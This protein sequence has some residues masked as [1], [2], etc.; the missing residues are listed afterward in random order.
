MGLTVR[1]RMLVW[2]LL[3]VLPAVVVGWFTVGLI[4][5]RLSDRVEVDLANIRRLEAAR[6]NEALDDYVADAA[7][8]AAGPHVIDFANGV[9]AAREGRGRRS[10]GGYDGFEIVDPE[11]D[12][13]LA[14]LAAALQNKARTT[15]SEVVEL[16]L[17]G[18]DGSVLGE[19]AGFEWEPYDLTLVGRVLAEG[20]PRF[21]NAYRTAAGDDRLGLATPILTRGGAVVGALVLET[22]LGPVVDLVV[23]HEGF[24]QTSEA[25]IAQPTPDGD[26]EFIT[27]LRFERDAAFN[28]VVP[29]AKGLPINQSLLSPEGQVLR[30]PDYRTVDSILAI[31]TL[32]ATGWGLVVKIDAAEAYAPVGEVR[33]ALAFA[34]LGTLLVVIG[35]TAVLLNPLGRRLRRLSLAA[36][37]VAAGRYQSSIGD[38]S[39]DEIGVLARSIDQLAADLDADI[40]MRTLV[41]N[42]LR[43][44][45]THDDLTEIHNRHYA[46]ARIRELAQA[47]TSSWS[48]LFLDLDSFKSVNDS[49][50]HGVGDEVL[51]AVAGRLSAS[52]PGNA[53]V[54]RWGGDEFVI[55][56]PDTTRTEAQ[57]TAQAIRELFHHPVAT[58]AGEQNVHCSIGLATADTNESTL[59]EILNT[60]D[61]AM[62]AQKPRPR[63]GRPARSTTEQTIIDALND[64]RVHV[65]YQPIV[66]AAGPEPTVVG[67]EALV[68]LR[69]PEGHYLPPAEFLPAVIDR[70][71]GIDLDAQVARQAL[72]TCNRWLRDGRVTT[73][74]QI[75]V[76]L[77]AGSLNDPGL[78]QRFDDLLRETGLPPEMLVLEISETADRID[79]AALRRLTN[80]GIDIA[81]DD[82]GI[83]NSNYDRLL[84]VRPRYAK[85]DRR[86]LTARGDESLVLE[87]LTRTCEALNLR[88]VA[89]GI[90]TPAQRQL[91]ESLNIAYHQGFLFGQAIPADEF[92]RTWLAAS[93]PSPGEPTT[94]HRQGLHAR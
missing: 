81:L 9:A 29:A 39:S 28:K 68:R 21:G 88:M 92:S 25:H 52:A 80:A 74:F 48:L 20:R 22:N 91:A 37:Q 54:A 49:H 59:D 19:T 73:D 13:P 12:Q 61:S 32:E 58:S 26:A 4:D 14:E 38:T 1:A 76:N 64:Q 23:E 45:A 77:G 46:T 60:A 6:L 67:A 50:G 55:V 79:V 69:T 51:Q 66:T 8:L 40:Q 17:V 30:S 57:A 71:P 24:G 56:L 75:S 62:F 11:A 94:R 18:L 41:E 47:A 5:D 2:L 15:G 70:Q 44:Q 7:S 93:T 36:K 33:R 89:E 34:G 72:E 27:L 10:I 53:T 84:E 85:I 3:V 86:W 31:E 87:S 16:Q 63:S 35:C 82:V 83:S 90:E 43:H 42:R 65:W 78:A